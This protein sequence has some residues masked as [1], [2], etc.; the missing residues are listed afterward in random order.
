MQLQ[1]SKRYFVPHIQRLCVDIVT[2]NVVTRPQ[3]GPIK[4]ELYII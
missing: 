4:P 3:I 1:W 2:K